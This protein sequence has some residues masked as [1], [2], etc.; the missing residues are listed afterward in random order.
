MVKRNRI[1]TMSRIFAIVAV[2]VILGAALGAGTALAAKG[3]VK[4]K[5]GGNGGGGGG[6]NGDAVATLTVSPDPVPA[7]THPTV[8]GTGFKPGETVYVG[9]PGDLR[10]TAVTADGSGSFS[11]MYTDRDLKPWT[12]TMEALGDGKGKVKWVVRASVTFQVV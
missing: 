9:I 12:Y 2:V 5:P 1:A 6:G 8:T 3:G 4:G 10:F 7:F 11:F